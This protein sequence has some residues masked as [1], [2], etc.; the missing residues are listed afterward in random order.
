MS[1]NGQVHCL[2][3]LDGPNCFNSQQISEAVIEAQ[4]NNRNWLKSP[5]SGLE[6]NSTWPERFLPDP[7]TIRYYRN[8]S[9]TL[10]GSTCVPKCRDAEFSLACGRSIMLADSPIRHFFSL[11]AWDQLAGTSLS[12]GDIIPSAQLTCELS[13]P[14]HTI[15]L[16]TVFIHRVCGDVILTSFLCA[17]DPITPPYSAILFTS[18]SNKS[19]FSSQHLPSL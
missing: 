1:N 2:A 19:H 15:V 4:E 16:I 6:I 11:L 18:L 10:K 7:L 14:A 5:L 12:A 17:D 8:R 3:C 13:W 9:L